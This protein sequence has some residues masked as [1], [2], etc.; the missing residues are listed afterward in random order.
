MYNENTMKE[1]TPIGK[2]V[3]KNIAQSLWEFYE[4]S[5]KKYKYGAMV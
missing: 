1:F 2:Y 3:S 4:R 5:E